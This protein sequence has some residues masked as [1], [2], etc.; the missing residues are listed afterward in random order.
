M[1]IV[2][3]LFVSMLSFSI[4]A[5]DST[6]FY[7]EKVGQEI[8]VLVKKQHPLSKPVSANS[9]R[10]NKLN[11]ELSLLKTNLN[12]CDKDSLN[13]FQSDTSGTS[14][15]SSGVLLGCKKY[16]QEIAAIDSTIKRVVEEDSVKTIKKNKAKKEVSLLLTQKSKSMQQFLA[17]KSGKVVFKYNGHRFRAFIYNPKEHSLKMHHKDIN[18]KVF[19]SLYKVFS[20]TK[21]KGTN[22]SVLMLTNGGMYTKTQDPEGLF[23]ESGVEKF[24]MDTLNIPNLNFYMMPNGVFYVNNKGVPFVVTSND[25]KEDSTITYA[26]QS[27]PQLLIEGNYHPKFNYGAPSKKIRSGVGIFDGDK[28]VFLISDDPVNFYEFSTVFKHLFSCK[29]ALFLDGAISKMYLGNRKRDL[30]GQFGVIISISEK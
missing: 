5:Q 4:C 9:T 21:S 8:K 11:K 1:K 25:Y 27:G 23:I 24:P 10:L 7:L 26:T 13:N 19:G 12:N 29:D 18:K 17:N 3:F 22:N 16:R 30:G 20:S 6:S 15:D 14:Q 2:V 28:A